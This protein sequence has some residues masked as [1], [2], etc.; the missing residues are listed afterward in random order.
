MNRIGALVDDSIGWTKYPSGATALIHDT[1][2]RAECG[3]LYRYWVYSDSLFW[4]RKIM[5]DCARHATVTR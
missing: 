2:E 3:C 4:F 1:N 5:L